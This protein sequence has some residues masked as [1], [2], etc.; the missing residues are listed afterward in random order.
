MPR[1]QKKYHFIYKTVCLV[2]NKFY[3]GM[4]S[5]NNLEDGYL[6]SGKRL[7]YSVNKHGAENHKLNI[8]EYLDSRELLREREEELITEEMLNDP[9][10]MNLTLGG[11]GDWY[12]E[13]LNSDKQRA[14]GLK[15]NKKMKELRENDKEWK[16]SLHE[17]QSKG[18][19]KSYKDGR[20]VKTPDWTGKKHSE[21]S[22][23][24]IKATRALRK[25][26]LGEKNSQFGSKWI[27]NGIDIK[28]LRKDEILP[29]GWKYGKKLN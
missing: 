22:K 21:E 11:G 15:G 23:A 8:L 25:P 9:M 17:A 27:T 5:T 16:Q 14:K 18:H 1:K 29:D 2:T 7:R 3:Y 4:H 13:N 6:G 24:K 28:K 26:G 12:H 19:K 10:C 20:I